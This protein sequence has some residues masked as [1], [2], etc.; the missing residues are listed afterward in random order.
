M[1]NVDF[2]VLFLDVGTFTAMELWL[3]GEADLQ[4]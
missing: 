1:L 2:V 4:L 3:C